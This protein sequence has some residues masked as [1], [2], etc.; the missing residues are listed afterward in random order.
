MPLRS[1]EMKQFV[2]FAWIDHSIVS[3]KMENLNLNTL[4]TTTTKF[5]GSW[6]LLEGNGVTSL[7]TQQRTFVWRES[8]LTVNSGPV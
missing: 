3:C 6:Q 5:K 2:L 4:T 1:S 7:Y 8:R